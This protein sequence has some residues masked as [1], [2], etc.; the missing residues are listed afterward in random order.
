MEKDEYGMVSSS[1]NSWCKLDYIIM[2][3]DMGQKKKERLIWTGDN[4]L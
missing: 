1:N 3:D 2:G 4:F